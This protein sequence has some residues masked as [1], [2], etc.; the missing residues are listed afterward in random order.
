[1]VILSLTVQGWTAPFAARLTGVALDGNGAA[2][3]A[4]PWRSPG[5]LAGAASAVVALAACLWIAGASQPERIIS[6]EPQTAEELEEMLARS[7]PAAAV[8]VGA[9]PPDL[10]AVDDTE[11]RKALFLGAAAPLIDAENAAIAAER[12]E[13]GDDRGGAQRPPPD[14]GR[15]GAARP[16]GPAL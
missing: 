4:P 12:A 14:F 5:V 9:L 7:G 6:A 16:A 11:R 13:L 1:V 2:A 10:R 15:A 8:L 3:K